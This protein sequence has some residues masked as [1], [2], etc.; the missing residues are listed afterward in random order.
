MA[1]G[2]GFSIVG[3]LISAAMVAC[4]S[5]PSPPSAEIIFIEGVH[6]LGLSHN[7]EWVVGVHRAESGRL[8]PFRWSAETGVLDLGT[9]EPNEADPYEDPM[10]SSSRAVAVSDDG[11][12]VVGYL[13]TRRMREVEFDPTSGWIRESQYVSEGFV[14]YE[15][16]GIW[17]IFNPE[18]YAGNFCHPDIR[19]YDVTPDGF[20]IVGRST[21]CVLYSYDRY[22]TIDN[23]TFLRFRNPSDPV[24]E[25]GPTFG[26][27]STANSSGEFDGIASGGR[28]I[29]RNPITIVGWVTPKFDEFVR[30]PFR[31]VDNSDPGSDMAFGPREPLGSLPGDV[32]YSTANDIS[33]DRSTIVGW[34]SLS[35]DNLNLGPSVPFKWTS[36]RGLEALDVPCEGPDYR[37]GKAYSVSAD[38]KVIVGEAL[39]TPCNRTTAVVWTPLFGV[40]ALADMLHDRFNNYGR[41]TFDTAVGVSDDGRVIVAYGENN[42]KQSGTFV[43]RL[44]RP[45]NHGYRP[46]N[47]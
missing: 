19:P 6:A 26:V 47:Q 24:P 10:F 13:E 36:D 45:A 29:L 31:Q 15:G 9:I 12:V 35:T 16:S 23:E 30:E 43:I 22:V 42:D 18:G 37:R 33:I 46:Q 20:Y 14:W 2:W 21:T 41:W 3:L 44:S 11:K 32:R 4:T 25:S 27:Y 39:N 5:P 34:S 1:R 38:G 7:G 40:E 17:P 8:E 28:A